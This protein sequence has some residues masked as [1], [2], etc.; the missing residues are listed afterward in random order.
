M[1][2]RVGCI[3][4]VAVSCV[5]CA[6][7]FIVAAF[8]LA[9]Q[10]RKAVVDNYGETVA[11][12]CNPPAGGAASNANLPTGTAGAA[13]KAVALINDDNRRHAFHEDMP[14]DLRAD[15]QAELQVVICVAEREIEVENCEY[16]TDQADQTADFNILRIQKVND[17]I[18][19][20]ATT[21]QRIDELTVEGAMP[22]ECKDSETGTKGSTKKLTGAAVTYNQFETAIRPVLAGTA[23]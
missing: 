21:G 15:D 2:R 18:L 23:Q 1:S 20:N 19:L 3:L 13:L 4:I 5:V 10:E 6:G 17:L 12:M 11:E 8:I 7:V 16:V 9:E 14:E 22:E